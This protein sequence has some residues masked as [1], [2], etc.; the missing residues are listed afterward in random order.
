MLPA[1]QEISVS[2]NEATKDHLS[3]NR[4]GTSMFKINFKKLFICCWE[5]ARELNIFWKK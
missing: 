1:K 4:P 2:E 5:I 3:I